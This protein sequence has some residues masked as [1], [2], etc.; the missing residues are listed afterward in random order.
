MA[1][2]RLAAGYPSMFTSIV[3]EAAMHLPPLTKPVQLD[4]LRVI[5]QQLMQIFLANFAATCSQKSQDE[6]AKA[7]ESGDQDAQEQWIATNLN[8][9]QDA[10]AASRAEGVLDELATKLPGTIKTEYDA[11]MAAYG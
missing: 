5:N 11:F 2:T 1:N 10:D 9:D 6:L 7:M 4:F 8:F 3:A